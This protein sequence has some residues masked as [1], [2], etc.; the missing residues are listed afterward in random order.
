MHVDFYS[1][2]P[3][4]SYFKYIDLFTLLY[5]HEK[6][7]DVHVFKEQKDDGTSE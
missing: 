6:Y 3:T 5:R 7:Q 4:K 2:F 1:L